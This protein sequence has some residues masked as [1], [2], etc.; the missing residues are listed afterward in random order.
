[1]YTA[2]QGHFKRLLSTPRAAFQLYNGNT[3]FGHLKGNP[4]T[5]D[6]ADLM[7]CQFMD[8]YTAIV[9]QHR[10]PMYLMQQKLKS[11]PYL[12]TVMAAEYSLQAHWHF[13]RDQVDQTYFFG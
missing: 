11:L 7:I 2:Y 12:P 13:S 6:Q 9:L 3:P 5:T 10:Y 8:S 1:M 4:Q